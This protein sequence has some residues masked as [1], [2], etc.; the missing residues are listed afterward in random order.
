[1]ITSKIG[2]NIVRDVAQEM[3]FIKYVCP[4]NIIV[5]ARTIQDIS[6]F[7]P[8]TYENSQTCVILFSSGTTGLP[9]GVELTHKSILLMSSLGKLV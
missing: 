7:V 1:M 5:N 9:K 6:N 8:T 3:N 2:L 4:I